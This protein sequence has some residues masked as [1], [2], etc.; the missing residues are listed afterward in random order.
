[1][2][3]EY[4]PLG[5]WQLG[6]GPA[7][8]RL[9]GAIRSAIERGDY[10][11][12][13]RLPAERLLAKALSVSRTTVVGA[14]EE[15]RQDGWLESRQGSGSRVCRPKPASPSR[16]ETLTSRAFQ[17]NTVFRGLVESSGS[18]I[19]FLGAHLPGAVEFLE[20]AIAHAGKDLAGWLGHSGYSALGIPPL[21]QRI[22]EHITASGLP[23]KAE[24][25]LV[26]HG[27]QQ[28]IGLATQLYVQG[29]DAVVLEDPTYVGAIDVFASAGARLLPIPVTQEGLRL[30][31]LRDTMLRET[32]RLAYLMPTFHNPLGV[33]A[34]DASRREIVR[35]AEERGVPI[36]ED[37]TLADLTLGDAAP[38]PPLAAYA[39]S[40]AVLTVGSLSKL[41]WGGLRVGWVRAPEEIIARLAR[42]KVMSDLGN[43]V[44]SQVVAARLLARVEE[45]KVSRRRLLE[46]RLEIASRELARLL[47]DWRWRRPAGGL[48]LWVRIPRGSAAEFVEVAL[49]HGVSLVAGSTCSPRAAYPDFLRIPFVQEPEVLRDGIRRLAGAWKTYAPAA[50]RP[51]RATLDV[52]V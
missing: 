34:S 44:V 45:I 51:E 15:L 30:D 9:A 16:R 39:R 11:A 20:D 13:S 1:M 32:P 25:V 31:V 46:E 12:G 23:T 35:L 36:L 42:L 26:T 24:E 29:N 41:I 18:T 22:A 27:A 14:Y 10:P 7:Y 5:G 4:R 40:G 47:P 49:R 43:S 17:R 19:E 2:A 28:A 37:H 48:S 33:V 8:R 21:R 38:P 6:E 3:S 52:L 50:A